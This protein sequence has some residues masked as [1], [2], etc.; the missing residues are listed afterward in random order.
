MARA[1]FKQ[2]W[3]AHDYYSRNDPKLQELISELGYKGL[4]IFW[5]IIEILYEQGGYLP[6]NKIK[7]TA[8]SLKIKQDFLIKVLENYELFENDEDF[9]FSNACLNR[10]KE[11]EEISAIRS[12]N[13][14]KGGNAKANKNVANATNLPEQNEAIREEDITEQDIT[15][16]NIILEKSTGD[17]IVPSEQ[18]DSLNSPDS[19][20]DIILALSSESNDLSPSPPK[21]DSL[22][23]ICPTDNKIDN[24]NPVKKEY[25]CNNNILLTDIEYQDFNEIVKSKKMTTNII[26][27]LS[28][29]IYEEKYKPPYNFPKLLMSFLYKKI[30]Y[31]LNDNSMIEQ[32]GDNIVLLSKRITPKNYTS[33]TISA[34]DFN[35]NYLSDY[36]DDLIDILKEAN[37][38]PL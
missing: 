30:F 23:H 9:Y 25:G 2:P 13:G 11:K 4:G 5:C 24:I 26:N 22:S 21:T 18:L 15:G 31:I 19:S 14:T 20:S 7:S 8:F 3:F 36:L 29:N 38:Y 28:K 35:E 37:L 10:L 6:K 33:N 1:K 32:D 27:S 12:E 34:K 17:N 16:D